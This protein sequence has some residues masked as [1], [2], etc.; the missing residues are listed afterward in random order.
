MFRHGVDPRPPKLLCNRC[1]WISRNF[2]TGDPGSGVG[3]VLIA[4]VVG[5]GNVILL[6][7]V[8]ISGMEMEFSL[9]ISIGDSC[10]GSLAVT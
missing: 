9:F 1:V 3:I 5:T 2:C 6:G 10:R 8:L 4:V 7:L